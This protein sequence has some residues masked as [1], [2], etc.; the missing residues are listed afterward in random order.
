MP[1]RFPSEFRQYAEGVR[2][3]ERLIADVPVDESAMR[4]FK[5][6]AETP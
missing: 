4:R 3:A 6:K 5:V 1:R 2:T